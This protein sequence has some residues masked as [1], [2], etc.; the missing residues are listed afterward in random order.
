MLVGALPYKKW[1]LEGPGL[2]EMVILRGL[3]GGGALSLQNWSR[4]IRG[5]PP[6][7]RWSGSCSSLCPVSASLQQPEVHFD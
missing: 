4:R 1:I 6:F 2:W 5:P 7:S 3:G